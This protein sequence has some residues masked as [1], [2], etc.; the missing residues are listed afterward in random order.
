MLEEGQDDVVMLDSNK[1]DLIRG[2]D[3]S[4][5]KGGDMGG[6]NRNNHQ[7]YPSNNPINNRIIRHSKKNNKLSGN[8]N[9]YFNNSNRKRR[10]NN[11][12]SSKSSKGIT[13]SYNIGTKQGNIG[14]NT[15]SNNDNLYNNK[16]I[17]SSASNKDDTYR[18]NMDIDEASANNSKEE[19]HY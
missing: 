1:I 2:K 13:T 12:S 7:Q 18:Y 8:N 10:G 9:Y 15:V 19:Y 6:K 4:S 11:N 3:S 5:I 16:K 14:V 17:S